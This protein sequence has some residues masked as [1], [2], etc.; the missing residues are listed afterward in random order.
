MS[1]CRFSCLNWTSQ[2]Y[3]YEGWHAYVIHVAANK[4]A[5]PVLPITV[6]M[7]DDP[8]EYLRQRNAQYKDMDDIEYVPIGLP[9]DG[10]KFEEPN[11][12]LA[13]ARLCA[14][15]DMGYIVPDYAI[16]ALAEEAREC[17]R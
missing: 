15:R 3:V 17:E 2:V 14:L 4:P 12:T 6:S 8:V 11:A 1:Y 16:E 9:H 13:C 7:G 5:R 10:A